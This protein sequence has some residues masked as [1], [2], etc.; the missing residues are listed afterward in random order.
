MPTWSLCMIVKDEEAV[1]ERCLNSAAALADEIV[2]VDTGSSDATKEI[3]GRFTDRI[4]GFPWKDDFAA[5]RNFSFSLAEGEYVMWL[6][7]DDVLP[8]DSLRLLLAKKASLSG[9]VD[10]IMLPY[11][12]AFD[13]TGKA[14]FSCER[15]RVI[16]N[17]GQCV[18]TGAVHEAI[19]PFGRILRLPAPIRHEKRGE[20]DRDRN[21]RIYERLLKENRRLDAR[22]QYYYGRELYFH[23]KYAKAE[24]VLERF[25]KEPD[26]WIVNR[27]EAVRLLA[28]CRYRQ[29]RDQEAFETLL[30]GLGLGAPQPEL[31]CDLGKHFLDREQYGAAAFWYQAALAWSRSEAAGWTETDGGFAQL[32]CRG[33]LPCIQLCVCYD[34]MGDH[35]RA[36]AYN[37]R[38]GSYRPLSPYFLQNRRYFAHLRDAGS[39]AGD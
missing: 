14:V 36:E 18:W 12:T 11:E 9:D 32:D 27:M 10:V 8:E 38:A 37:E 16:R 4:Y 33:F 15:E 39:M 21:L 7:A 28:Y 26:A 17:C 22:Q 6:D 1:L 24:A 35:K 23:E 5:A 13:E 2:I 30:S 20:G 34:R 31:C 25:L 29:G 19:V 3:A